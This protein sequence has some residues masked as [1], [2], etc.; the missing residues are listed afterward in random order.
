LL[1]LISVVVAVILQMTRLPA[2]LMLGPMVAGILMEAG[3][4]A[5]HVPNTLI[6]PA[7]API[8]CLIARSI[9][10]ESIHEFAQQWFLFLGV[11]VVIV[12]DLPGRAYSRSGRTFI[13]RLDHNRQGR[14]EQ[15]EQRK[16]EDNPPQSSNHAK[17]HSN[18]RRSFFG[19]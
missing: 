19:P 2:A 1:A 9:T 12:L 14:Q 18:L 6:N 8:G 16:P 10:A 7:Q 17:N 3:G 5:V 11:V 4:G 13:K 15:H